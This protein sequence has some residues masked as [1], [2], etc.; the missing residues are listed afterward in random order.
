M[1]TK[2]EKEER[3]RTCKIISK[4]ESI[5]SLVGIY[6]VCSP[7]YLKLGF[8]YTEIGDDYPLANSNI[9]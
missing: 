5:S 1:T 8:R 4:L 6:I 2:I 9:I 3:A 7:H